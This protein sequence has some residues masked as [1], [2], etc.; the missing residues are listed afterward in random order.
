MLI[1]VEKSYFPI[2]FIILDIQLITHASSP[3]LFVL[4]CPFLTSSNAL[5]N[6]TSGVLK[7]FFG[8][9]TVELNIFKTRI[10]VGMKRMLMKLMNLIETFDSCVNH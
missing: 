3:N 9:K 6:F 8:N 7:L 4:V 1:K 2:D 5:I 10:N